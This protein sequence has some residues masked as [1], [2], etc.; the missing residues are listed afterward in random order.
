[1]FVATI[2]DFLG[3]ILFHFFLMYGLLEYILML[4]SDQSNSTEGEVSVTV[5]HSF[6]DKSVTSTVLEHHLPG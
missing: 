4:F 3:H 2:W 5:P 1:M 6:C